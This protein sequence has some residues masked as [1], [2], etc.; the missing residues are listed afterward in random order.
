MVHMGARENNGTYGMRGIN[1][2]LI[3]R[4]RSIQKTPVSGNGSY[5]KKGK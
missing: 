5:I 3:E 4:S 2:E 1:G